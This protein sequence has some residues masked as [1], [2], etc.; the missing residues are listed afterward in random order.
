MASGLACVGANAPGIR[1][2]ITDGVDGLLVAP[3]AQAVRAAVERVLD[4]P[5][6]A[7]KL[8]DAARRT[9]ETRYDLD[10]LLTREITLLATLAE[11]R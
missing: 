6:L 9:V 2:V 11:G 10:K 7:E 3:T 4:E 8:G 1:D 5:S